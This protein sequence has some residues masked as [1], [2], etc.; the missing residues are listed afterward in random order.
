MAQRK[1]I[2]L[3]TM[4]LWVLSLASLNGLRIQCCH[5]LWY[6]L[7]RSLDMAWLWCG[8][9]TVAPIQPLAWESPYAMGVALKSQKKNR[10]KNIK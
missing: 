3:G 4:R 9:A 1:R 6:R 5:E 10:N 8:L 2:Q 7:Q